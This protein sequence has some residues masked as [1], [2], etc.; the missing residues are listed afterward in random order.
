V[1]S[2]SWYIIVFLK[3]KTCLIAYKTVSTLYLF[4]LILILLSMGSKFCWQ[5]H[6]SSVIVNSLC[7]SLFHK[8]WV[9]FSLHIV[10]K[11]FLLPF[12]FSFLFLRKYILCLSKSSKIVPQDSDIL[13]TCQSV[14]PWMD[15]INLFSTFLVFYLHTKISINCFSICYFL[16][17]KIFI[18]PFSGVY[19]TSGFS[20][21][22][23][24]LSSACL[25]SY[26]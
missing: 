15:G 14:L 17:F 20:D 1:I 6:S 13:L 8:T 10:V 26:E 25:Y 18:L 5:I 7:Y 3:L 2:A 4:F 23:F 21:H 24:T 12:Y 19:F 16:C 9:K 22:S 11:Y